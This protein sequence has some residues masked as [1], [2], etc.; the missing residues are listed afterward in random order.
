MSYDQHSLCLAQ[1]LPGPGECKPKS[2]TSQPFTGPNPYPNT[3]PRKPIQQPD[4]QRSGTEPVRWPGKSRNP[5]SSRHLIRKPRPKLS[6]APSREN[7]PSKMPHNRFSRRGL[8]LRSSGEQPDISGALNRWT[9]TRRCQKACQVNYLF[10]FS[11]DPLSAS[12]DRGRNF[13]RVPHAGGF[14]LSEN[15]GWREVFRHYNVG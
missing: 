10:F 5:H 9:V 6:C 13:P 11:H 14:K 12:V 3:A 15:A 8:W 4:K 2:A 1:T 7:A